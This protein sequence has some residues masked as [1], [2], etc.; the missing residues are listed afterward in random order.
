MSNPD[1]GKLHALPKH[2]NL[3][4]QEIVPIQVYPILLLGTPSMA[5]A[6]IRAVGTRLCSCLV[7]HWVKYHCPQMNRHNLKEYKSSDNILTIF[8]Q[9]SFPI[10]HHLLSLITCSC[11]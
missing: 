2:E 7:N 6:W 1:E 8:L 11:S 9:G 10:S 5:T 3:H 4:T